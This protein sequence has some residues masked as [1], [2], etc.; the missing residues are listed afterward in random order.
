[1]AAE[2]KT[3][4]QK[5]D[6]LEQQVHELLN[7]NKDDNFSKIQ[8][9]CDSLLSQ[10]NALKQQLNASTHHGKKENNKANSNDEKKDSNVDGNDAYIFLDR[11]LDVMQKDIIPE[12]EIGVSNGNKVF[13]AAVLENVANK[14]W[15]LIIVGTNCE[16]ASPLWHGEMTTIEK[17]YKNKLNLKYNVSKECIFLSTHQPC[18]MCVSAITWS[19]FKKFYYF[20]DYKATN[21]QFN[22]AHDSSIINELFMCDDY[23]HHNKYFESYSIY[24]EIDKIKNKEKREKLLKK[25]QLINQ[26]YNKLSDTYQSGKAS[27][28]IPL[29]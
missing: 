18:T 5:C 27:N 14:N 1:M 29:K 21:K 16:T 23:K 9:T 26:D 19:G 12:T 10:L 15:P 6:E 17:F 2:P 4:S 28:T 8:D 22:I 3:N 24:Q 25:C 13:G 11:L 20:F 7:I